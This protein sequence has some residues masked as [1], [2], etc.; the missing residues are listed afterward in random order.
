MGSQVE[1]TPKIR[2]YVSTMSLREPDSLREIRR[3]TA[4]MPVGDM[5]VTPEEGQFLNVL[6]RATGARRA[7]EVGV[8]TGY[9]LI[10]TAMALPE[11]GT[12]IACEINPHWAE[13]ALEHAR[14]VGVADRIDLRVGDAR[15]SLTR[16][17][18]EPGAPGSFDFAFLDAD[19]P[20]YLA[21]YE[22]ILTLLR[23]GGVL[24]V[25]NVL[26]SGLVAEESAADEDTTALRAFNA[27]VLADDRVHLSMLPFA[28]GITIVVKR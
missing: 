5:Q 3:T 20:N 17:S 10:A 6:V 27:A 11:D 8:F 25:D 21:Y 2:D 4:R 15:E 9:S 23:S 1:I 24:V 13:I 28:D 14:R 26:W 22:A 19:K 16:L 18:A 7:L 12:V